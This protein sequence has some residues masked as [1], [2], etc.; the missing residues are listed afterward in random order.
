MIYTGNTSS[1]TIP[2]ALNDLQENG[3]LKHNQNI[4]VLGFGVGYS[5]CG[6]VIKWN[7]DKE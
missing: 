4:L 1:A 6:T 3:L 5:W 2:I 7:M